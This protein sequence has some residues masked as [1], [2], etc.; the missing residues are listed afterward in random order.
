MT[1]LAGNPS[2]K[3]MEVGWLARVTGNQRKKNEDGGMYTRERIRAHTRTHT[4]RCLT[5]HKL[6]GVP[7]AGEVCM[8][9]Q[10]LRER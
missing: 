1:T 6:E 3:A 2:K 10:G 8:I 7:T 9:R 5:R 4:H